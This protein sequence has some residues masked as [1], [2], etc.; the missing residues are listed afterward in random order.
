MKEELLQ[1]IWKHQYFNGNGLHTE[2]GEPLQIISP[3]EQNIHQGPDFLH[4]CIR[5][6]NSRWTG[7]IELH[8]RAS[9][10]EDHAHGNDPNY[11][12]VILHVV[13][14]DDRPRPALQ[15]AQWNEE[16]NG[17]AL[18][19]RYIP[20]LVLQHRVPKLLLGRYEEWMRSQSFVPC[21]RQLSQIHP[22]TLSAWKTLLVHRR[23]QRAT[24]RIAQSLA[25]NA[26][27]WDETAWR[28]LARNFGLR[29]NGDAFETIA[30]SLPTRLLARYKGRTELLEALLLGQAGLLKQDCQELYS[31]KPEPY[32]QFLQREF[33]HLQNK[34]Q[35]RA[36]HQP[37]LLL[38]MR[39]GNFPSVR[40]AQLA[41]L[42][43]KST[44]WFTTIKETEDLGQLRMMMDVT[45][46]DYWDDHYLPGKASSFR[47][48]TLGKQMKDS[49]IINTFSPLLYAYGH[50][51]GEKQLRD[52]AIRW[53]GE[54]AAETN[55]ITSGWSRLG[56]PNGNAAD[57]QALLELK[58]HY[59]EPGKCLECMI[60]RTL[61]G[62]TM[63]AV[64]PP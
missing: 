33:R 8:V 51:R 40:L 18:A 56:I 26:Q 20:M 32:L 6:G 53:I 21:E 60:G 13:W 9:S 39:P 45:A 15:P 22:D 38:R 14:E 41:A 59:C 2:N 58:K 47:K 50:L 46:S 62:K 43:S 52:R 17:T 23:M 30:Q 16:G 42:L 25:T 54:T 49:I 55:R 61:L 34:H 27:H 7:H 3:G 44:A 1:F 24:E 12:N 36:I 37:V 64:E 5:I 35:L 31:A 28:L 57:S 4:A 19:E 63:M 11:D 10:W 29:V 48:K